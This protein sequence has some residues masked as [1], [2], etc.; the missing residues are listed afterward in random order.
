VGLL[1]FGLGKTRVGENVGDKSGPGEEQVGRRQEEAIRPVE[2]ALSSW[3]GWLL[4]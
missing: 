1:A 2:V 4:A 3:L